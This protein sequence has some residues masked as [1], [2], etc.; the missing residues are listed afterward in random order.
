M[1]SQ[2]ELNMKIIDNFSVNRRL[3]RGFTDVTR[4]ISAIL[5]ETEKAY[6]VE[7][8]VTN[9][10]NDLMT[11]DMWIPKSCIEPIDE[12]TARTGNIVIDHV[13]VIEQRKANHTRLVDY[14]RENGI[15]GVRTSMHDLTIVEMLRDARVTIPEWVHISEKERM[16]RI[17]KICLGDG[18]N[19]EMFDSFEDWA[20]LMTEGDHASL[21]VQRSDMN[22]LAKGIPM[23]WNMSASQLRAVAD[24]CNKIA[25]D[26]DASRPV[27]GTENSVR[28]DQKL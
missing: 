20:C 8:G 25:N 3:P 23:T 11:I 10:N 24:W 26:L 7:T 16:D 14:A 12:Y 19:I 5:Q 4:G 18:A 1:S 17:D 22:P 21:K 13:A 28:H 9:D 27:E 6:R 15:K 2:T